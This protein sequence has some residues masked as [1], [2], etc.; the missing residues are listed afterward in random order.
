[1]QTLMVLIRIEGV[2][3]ERQVLGC[4]RI[5]ISLWVI[6]VVRQR[7]EGFGGGR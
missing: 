5:V 1:V 6:F 2:S 3:S 7:F 4:M